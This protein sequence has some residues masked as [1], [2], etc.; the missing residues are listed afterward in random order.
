MDD[1]SFL[2][3]VDPAP[4]SGG[5]AIS[6]LT[7]SEAEVARSAAAELAAELGLLWIRNPSNPDEARARVKYLEDEVVILEGSARRLFISTHREERSVLVQNI[8]EYEAI[9]RVYIEKRDQYFSLKKKVERLARIRETEAA[10]AKKRADA[11]AKR[12]S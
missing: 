8:N 4:E 5:A 12:Y 11:Y 1:L 2:D 9:E 10:T 3:P 7:E 6:A